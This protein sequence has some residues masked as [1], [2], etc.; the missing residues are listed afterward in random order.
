MTKTNQTGRFWAE[1][2]RMSLELWREL[3]RGCHG[4]AG[5][6]VFFE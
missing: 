1:H 4:R 5:K 6:G 3:L 2:L